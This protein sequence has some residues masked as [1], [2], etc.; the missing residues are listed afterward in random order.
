M[1]QRSGIDA[2]RV[3]GWFVENVAGVVPPLD[4]TLI[5]G[6]HSNLTYR[7]DD[8]SGR[9]WALRRP[10]LGH[11]LATAHDV[12][13]EHRIIAALAPTAV[14]VPTPVGVCTDESV[15]GAP[16]FVMDFVA[17]TVARDVAAGEAL[18]PHLRAR[19]SESLVDALAD[20]HA[21]DVDAVGLGDLA[22]RD[23]YIERQLRRWRSQYEATRTR[24][25]P[26]MTKVP[27]ILASS[28]PPQGPAG[29]VHGDFRLDNCIVDRD[30][31]VA[32]VLDWELCTLGD[33]LADLGLLLVYWAEPGDEDVALDSPPTSVPGFW[34]RDQMVER[35]ASRSGRDVSGL[36]FYIAFASWRLACI[37]EGVHARYQAGAMGESRPNFGLD[38][39]V[40]R[41]DSLASRAE[42]MAVAL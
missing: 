26:A 25:I 36:D 9:S 1:E 29:I 41:I 12:V 28:I 8:R 5:A 18:E 30:G 4:F 13:R 42:S 20:I 10:P 6:G 34:S 33:V 35:Y 22:R 2:E 19:V 11:V 37:L 31:K 14:P 23:G 39:F 16:F 27:E 3:E 7:V 32:A 17:G 21:V 38:S 15:N 40:R 24:D